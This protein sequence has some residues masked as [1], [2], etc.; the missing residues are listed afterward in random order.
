MTT[1]TWG[2]LLS[3]KQGVSLV[4]HAVITVDGTWGAGPN[5][6]P[7]NVVG[8]L[9]LFVDPDLCY[10]VN[11]PY[12][13]AFGPIG[14]D[15]MSPSYLQSVLDGVA[16]IAAWIIAHP[17]QTFALIGYSQGAEVTSRIMLALMGLL[18]IGV[19]LTPY[20]KNCIGGITFGNPCRMAGAHAPG[21]ADPGGRGISSVNMTALPTV[22]GQIVWA[23]YVH[24]QA[25]GDAGLDM[26]ASVPL[27]QVG[28]DMTVMYSAATGLQLNNFG[29]LTSDLVDAL[30]QIVSQTGL[31]PALAGGLGGVLNLGVMAIIGLLQGLISGPSATA[32]GTQAAVEAAVCGMEF[33]AAPGGATAPHISYLGEIPG[34]SNLVAPA[35]GFLQN[36]ATLTP[37]RCAA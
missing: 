15:P 31:L 8:G 6:Y 32:T 24:S 26:Y 28:N 3:Y 19:D 35:T 25:N 16:W 18:D 14:G 13:A 9:S 29:A 7:S 22:A 20:L 30:I 34:Y 4:R 37:A 11:V 33:M 17:F 5:Q 12:P 23:D 2:S 27:G 21:I 10:E 1:P 36:I